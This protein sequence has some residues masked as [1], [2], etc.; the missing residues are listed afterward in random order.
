MSVRAAEAADIPAILAIWNSFIRDTLVT[1][2]SE[3]KTE[4]DLAHVLAEKRRLGQGFFVAEQGGRVV[5]FA[6]WGAFRG[7]VGY[8]HSAEHSIL[9]DPDVQGS[10]LGRALMEMLEDHAAKSGIH[11]LFAGVSSANPAG[12]AF[13]RAIGFDDVV[14]LKEVGRKWDQWLDL[15]LMQK[16]LSQRRAGA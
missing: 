6:T 16:N 10:G 2:N 5:G 14:T 4:D 8:R 13:H 12:R 15:H 9:L 1:F 11:M 3:E 7:G